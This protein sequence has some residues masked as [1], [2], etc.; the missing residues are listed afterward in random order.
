MKGRKNRKQEGRHDWSG[1][2]DPHQMQGSHV[3]FS[4]GIF[5]WRD[6]TFKK[7]LRRGEVVL[8][9]KGWC[10]DPQRV[11]DTAELWCDKLDNGEDPGVK[12]LSVGVTR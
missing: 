6:K 8:R 10:S 12:T 2:W 4:V 3:T 5:Q 9:I 11:Y 1:M 7:G